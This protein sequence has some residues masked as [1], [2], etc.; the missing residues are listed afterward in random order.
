MSGSCKTLAAHGFRAEGV[1]A[2]T[3]SRE[4]G[5]VALTSP[6]NVRHIRGSVTDCDRT[7]RHMD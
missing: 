7:L 5:G 1:V 6:K 3:Q 4:L 2:A